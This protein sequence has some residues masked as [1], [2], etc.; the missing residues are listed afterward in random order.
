[1][2]RAALIA[3]AALAADQASKAYVLGV[4][5][6]DR[7]RAIDILPPFLNFR[8]AWNRGINFGLL[9]SDSEV[10]RWGLVVLALG[11]AVA[12]IIWARSLRH[13]LNHVLA[14]LLAGGAAGNALDRVLYG[15]VADFINMS[16]CGLDNPYAFNIADAAIFAGAFGLAFLSG[17][18]E[19][20]A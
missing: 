15:A 2:Y 12:V 17:S 19:K 3:M 13:P 11:V 10:L 8:M 14:G 20:R 9:A 1:M 16:C 7:V 6:L 5:E 4:L 18:L